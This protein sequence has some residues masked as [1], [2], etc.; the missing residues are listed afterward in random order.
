MQWFMYIAVGV[1]SLALIILIWT[2]TNRAIDDQAAEVRARTDQQVKGVAFVL[3]REVQNELHLIDQSL[4]IIQDDWKKDSDS[5]DL[6]AWRK[7][8]TALTDVSDDIFIANERQVIVQDTLPQAVGQG[9][10][11]AYVT[12]P[13]GSLEMF[14]SDGTKNADGKLPGA[15]RIEARQFVMYVVRPL[16]RPRGWWV[17]AS[18]RS[19]GITTLFSGA[20]LGKNGIVAMADMKRGALQAVVGS[21]AQFAN[22]VNISQSELI[23]QMRKNDS[24]IW[25]GVSPMDKIPRIIAY[26]RVPGRDMGILVGVSVDTAN[27]PLAGLAAMAQGLASVGSLV[28]LTIAAIVVWTIATASAAKQRRKLHE[29]TEMNLANARQELA[30]ARARGLLTEPEIGALISSPNDGV[31]RLDADQRLRTWN[32]R[33]AELAGVPLDEAGSPFED[34]LRRQ[35]EAGVFGDPAEADQDVSTRLTVIHT[36]GVAVVPPVQTGPA[37]EQVA[38]YVRGVTGGGH[39]IVLAGLENARLGALPALETVESEP[40]TAD[41]TTEW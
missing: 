13:N 7:Q 4:A 1:T 2:L 25:A 39:V 12:T 10:G 9:I 29:R 6:G 19:E 23:D 31:A 14:D 41:E 28:I 27:Q 16:S 36:S 33:F 35:A 11:S 40:E 17:G 5:V 30:N 22:M 38:M 32:P 37:G 34:L 18:Y 24:G 8:L 3:A 26:Q 20:R 15:D 21:S